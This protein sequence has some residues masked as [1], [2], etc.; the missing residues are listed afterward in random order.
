M[1]AG[2]TLSA[3]YEAARQAEDHAWGTVAK[4]TGTEAAYAELTAAARQASAI[5][6]GLGEQLDAE[7]LAYTAAHADEIAQARRL[8][9]A[10]A[11][12]ATPYPSIDDDDA[13]IWE[14]YRELGDAEQLEAERRG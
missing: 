5:R 11:A 12:T 10:P 3:Q 6:R 9:P 14:T 4:M 1:T 2:N 8:A 7:L 13:D